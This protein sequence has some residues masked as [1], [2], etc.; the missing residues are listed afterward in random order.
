MI[1]GPV[2]AA[3]S[4]VLA[5][6]FGVQVPYVAGGVFLFLVTLIAYPRLN[7]R[8]LANATKESVVQA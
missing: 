1:G 4:G 2:G 3:L 5:N 8:A 7:N 6:S